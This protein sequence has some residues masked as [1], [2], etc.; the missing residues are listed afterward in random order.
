VSLLTKKEQQCI[1]PC[2][3]KLFVLTVYAEH[4]YLGGNQLTG[5]IPTEVGLLTGLGEYTRAKKEHSIFHL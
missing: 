1:P 3:S 5:T 2:D 4:L